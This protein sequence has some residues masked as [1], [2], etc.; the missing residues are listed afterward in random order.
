M[1]MWLKFCVR[2][3]RHP[4]L[5][6]N[7]QT[8]SLFSAPGRIGDLTNVGEGVVAA[9][10]YCWWQAQFNFFTMCLYFLCLRV[11]AWNSS[12]N[13]PDSHSLVSSAAAIYYTRARN[14]SNRLWMCGVTCC[15]SQLHLHSL[16]W[17]AI[18]RNN[19]GWLYS[20]R[21]CIAQKCCW[22]LIIHSNASPFGSL[23]LLCYLTTLIFSHIWNFVC[24]L[25]FMSSV[26]IS[27]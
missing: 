6:C 15:M 19:G 23:R 3:F 12:N 24:A 26:N 4:P 5:T 20:W 2:S 17:C 27:F 25:L 21:W 10:R 13:N 9:A 16:L 7:V 18:S 14:S 11:R 22:L 1:Y 8:C